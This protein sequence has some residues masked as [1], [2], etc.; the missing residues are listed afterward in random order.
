MSSPTRNR[1]EHLL[2]HPDPTRSSRPRTTKAVP[3]TFGSGGRLAKNPKTH[4]RTSTPPGFHRIP[5]PINNDLASAPQLHSPSEQ[6]MDLLTELRATN[7]ALHR[8][9]QQQHQQI[10]G[11]Q[12]AASV[13]RAPTIIPVT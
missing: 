5:S 8:E 2:D 12:D 13:P 7:L 6:V 11:L 1:S 10:Q 3:L 9:I 4:R